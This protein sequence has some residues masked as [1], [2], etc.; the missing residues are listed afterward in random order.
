MFAKIQFK[1]KIILGFLIPIS[2]FVLSSIYLE[3]KISSVQELSLNIKN[4]DLVLAKAANDMKFDVA[5]VQQWLTDISA[6]RGAPGFDDGAKKAEEYAV[7]LH[8]KLEIFYNFYKKNH[9]QKG[10]ADVISLTEK[11]D[12]FFE[13]GKKMSIQ[14]IKGGP[15]A[16]NA[17]MGTFDKAAEEL[18]QLFMP[19]VAEHLNNMSKS[20]DEN[21]KNISTSM[22]IL[23]GSLVLTFILCTFIIYFLYKAINT[24]NFQFNEIGRFA[25]LL[26][27]GDLTAKVNIH[28][29]DEVGKL[30]DAFNS[31]MAF[32]RDAFQLK[33]LNWSD[34]ANQREREVLAQ[35][36]TKEA[37]QMAEKEKKEALE[38]TKI[39]ELEK[40][41]SIEAMKMASEEKRRAEELAV[42]ALEAKKFAEIEKSK[43]EKAM[44]MASEE[45][46]RAEELAIS[47]MEAQKS[48]EQSM[49]MASEEKK[50][51][52]VLAFNEKKSTEELRIKV[53]KILRVVRAAGDG[54]LT[55]SIN[56][57]GT[58]AIGQLAI[59]L[60][61]FFDKLSRDFILIDQYAKELDKQSCDLNSKS[62]ILG[63]N[64]KDTSD[65]SLSMSEQSQKVISNIRNLNSSTSEMKQAVSEISR[66]AS[67]TSRFSN[68]AVQY[69]SEA[70][71]IG[72]KLEESSKDIAQ[73]INSITAIARQTNLLALNATIEA[74]RAGESGK[75]FAVVANEVKELAK[76][77]ALAA[78]E[79]TT[80][81]LMIQA[82]SKEL[83]GSILKVNDLIGN[84]NHASGVVASATEEQFAT[85]DQFVEIIGY[86]VKEADKIGAGSSKV[87]TSANYTIEIVKEN[88]SMSQELGNTSEKLNSMVKKF[89]LKNKKNMTDQV[90]I[91]G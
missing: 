83:T 84:I 35:K 18:D 49:F 88:I 14:Y 17:F 75:G 61:V 55:Q 3:Y 80:K 26:K 32:I 34:I 45:K 54:D 87:N 38:A 59:G 39:A 8:K 16:G 77:S 73:F 66:Q 79:I 60:D 46:K 23:K 13:V 58:D 22:T 10:I 30:A 40:A 90:K 50:R 91:A 81:V 25:A 53:D 12:N 70:K 89:K 72:I 2:I 76:Q 78:N 19:F 4:R 74:A 86:S 67:E 43:S 31:T 15:A 44:V 62:E 28:S 6:T 57:D 52:E 20:V 64:A 24:I 5:E 42:S 56:I 71:E 11:F 36:Q 9:D 47:A 27:E 41:K 51:A 65:L 29:Q 63:T 7:D 33:K 1:Y 68:N 85:A 82:N 69:V 37:L 48:A 21:D